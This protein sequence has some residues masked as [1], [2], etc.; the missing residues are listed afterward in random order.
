MLLL[1]SLNQSYFTFCLDI[2]N[3]KKFYVWV[4]SLQFFLNTFILEVIWL[5]EMKWNEL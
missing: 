5:K 4:N 1:M 2:K 3:W